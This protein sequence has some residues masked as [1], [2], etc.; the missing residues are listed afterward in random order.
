MLQNALTLARVPVSRV[1]APAQNVAPVVPRVASQAGV[2]NNGPAAA[3]AAPA[4]GALVS[5]RSFSSTS[6]ARAQ[7]PTTT[8]APSAGA[9]PPVSDTN[10][11]HD[12]GGAKD[13]P[14]SR[15]ASLGEV[16]CVASG[17]GPWGWGLLALS[18]VG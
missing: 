9:Q 16:V 10:A 17:S 18:A 5:T 3:A 8:P 13:L 7:A 14:P 2:R 11:S 4:A 12:S 1:S 6:L 15:P